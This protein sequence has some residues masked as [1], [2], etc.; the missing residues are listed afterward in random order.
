MKIP[1]NNYLVRAKGFEPL[2]FAACLVR[3]CVD[4]TGLEPVTLSV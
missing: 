1:R 4:G 2:T 3:Y